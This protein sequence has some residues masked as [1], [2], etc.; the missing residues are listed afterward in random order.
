MKTVRLGL[1]GLGNMGKFHGAYLEQGKVQRCELTAVASSSPKKLAA[2]PKM[3]HFG[4][5]EELIESGVVDA[6]L[7]CTPHYQHT[8][9]GVAAFAQG[10]HVLVEK[11]VAVHVADADKLMAAAQKADRRLGAM[12]QLRVEPRYLKVKQLIESGELGAIV[13]FNWII[14][15]WFRTEAY[16]GSGGWR[17]TWSGEGGGA[18]LNQCPHQLDLLCWW[19]GLPQRVRGFCQFGRYHRIEVEDNVTMYFDYALGATGVFITSTGEAPGT[20]R[21]EIAGER[22][23]IVLEN[24][25][26]FFTRN[27]VGMSEFSRTAT[28]G[29]A[30]PSLWN[31]EIPTEPHAGPHAAVTQNFVD[32]ILDGVPLIASGSEGAASVQ[33]ANAALYSAWTGADVQLPLDA[34]AYAAALAKRVAESTFTKAAANAI[35]QDDFSKSFT[36]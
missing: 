9:L 12:F 16:Y 30:R 21:C 26:L 20:N 24:S 34:S 25:K 10:L 1:I 8:T 23:K 17:A 27:E 13:R 36:R 6:V 31:I 22:G 3:R 7:I 32:S 18:L 29:F 5:G 33:L 19:L 4:S 14:T 15:D 11:P 28:S 35:T 2:F